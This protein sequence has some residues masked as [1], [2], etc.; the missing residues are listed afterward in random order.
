M[1]VGIEITELDAAAVELS[2]VLAGGTGGL[3][4]GQFDAKRLVSARI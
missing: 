3:D 1:T 4:L 2:E